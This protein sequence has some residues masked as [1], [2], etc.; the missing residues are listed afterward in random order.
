MSGK[1]SAVSKSKGKMCVAGPQPETPSLA[2]LIEEYKAKYKSRLE[3]ELK[4]YENLKDKKEALRMAGL[5][6]MSNGKRY[7]HQYHLK[8]KVLEEVRDRLLDE[9]ENIENCQD[10]ET[11]LEIVQKCRIKGYGEVTIYDTALRIGANLKICPTKVYLHA[12]TRKGAAALG[13]PYKQPYLIR[14]FFPA[15]IQKLEPYDIENF[16]CIYKDL[17]VAY[18]R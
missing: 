5:C 10:F 12:G 4:F 1:P 7:P 3:N 9:L 8:A 18:K 15:E 16:V 14:E 17:L 6:L 11:L 2:T 13:L